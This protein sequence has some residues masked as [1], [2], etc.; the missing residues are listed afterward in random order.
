MRSWIKSTVLLLSTIAVFGGISTY[1]AIRQSKFVPEFYAQATKIHSTSNAEARRRLE[2][3][4]EQLQNSAAKLGSWRAAFSDEQ[5][6]AWLM[7]ELPKKFPRLAA[8]GASEPRVMI[9]DDRVLAAVRYSHGRFDTIISCEFVVALTEEPNMLAFRVQNLRAGALPL[10]L[11]QFLSGITK[12]A[13][14]GDLDIRWDM[15]EAGP[16]ALVTVPSEDPRYVL[17]PVVVES[18]LL[19]DGALLLSGHTGELA[20]QVF[21]PRGEVHQFV[22]YRPG[23]QR[24]DQP[25]RWTSSGKSDR[26]RIR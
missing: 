3:E 12:E 8:L 13:S 23:D 24:I 17:S 11:N 5:I 25:A 9:Q 22:S 2:A 21:K 6:N 16:I 10:P 14:R 15:T 4:V 26:S 19:Y 1:W 18:V 7:D 20:H